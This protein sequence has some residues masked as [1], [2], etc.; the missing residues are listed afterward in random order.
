MLEY[1]YVPALLGLIP[2]VIARRRGL[3]ILTWWVYGMLLWPVAMIHVWFAKP[4]S[5]SIIGEATLTRI[6]PFCAE[7]I[8]TAA[9]V[10][11]HCHR[12][13]PTAVAQARGPGDDVP[14][15][16]QD[17]PTSTFRSRAARAPGDDV[18]LGQAVAILTGVAVVGSLAAWWVFIR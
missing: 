17:T 3:P 4:G 15:V 10:C 12:D 7:A 6:C 16:A 18:P 8:Q 1:F 13:L 11:K 2:A 14:A 5:V 9:K